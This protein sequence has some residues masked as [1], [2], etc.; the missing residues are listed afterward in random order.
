MNLTVQVSHV[1]WSAP[2]QGAIIVGTPLNAAGEPAGEALA[3]RMPSRTL[4]D[5]ITLQGDL[6]RLH[7]QMEEYRGQPQFHADVAI[8]VRPYGRNMVATL[9][10][11]RFPGVGKQ[12]AQ[13][14]WERF[15]AGLRDVLEEG[16]LERLTEVVTPESAKV[17]VQGWRDL[18]PGDV[19]DWLDEHRFPVGLGAS[20]LKF[21][22]ECAA[23]KLHAD[24][25]RLLAFGQPWSTVDKI[26]LERLAVAPE[27]PRREHAAVAEALYRAYDKDGSTALDRDA[28]LT[29]AR[30]ILGG[31]QQQAERAVG[32]PHQG[33]GWLL[34]AS[35][36]LYQT[37]GAW[38]MERYVA[39]RLSRMIAHQDFPAQ[40]DL[41]YVHPI[42]FGPREREKIGYALTAW[43]ANNHPLGPGQKQAVWTALKHQFAVISGGAGVGK[44]TIL[45]AFYAG[46][47]A[48]GSE[49]VQMALAGRAAKRMHDATKR[50]AMTIAGFLHG[51]EEDKAQSDQS[52]RMDTR[53]YV[54]DEAS[55]LD[56]ATLYQVLRKI[57]PG[58]RLVLV[59]DDMQLPP[60]G[61]GL[62]F[63]L[64]C[65]PES[66]APRSHL[67][68]VYRQDGSTGIPAIGQ[69]IRDGGW[70][71]IPPYAGPGVG[72]SILPCSM[73]DVAD[74]IARLYDELVV[75]EGDENEVQILATSKGER[76][77]RPGTV[78]H[79]NRD[80]YQQRLSDRLAVKVRT[81]LSGFCEGCPIMFIEN[82][83]DRSLNNGSLGMI[84]RA[85]PGPMFLVKG[86]DEDTLV[87]LAQAM[88]SDGSP[89]EDGEI[90][91]AEAVIDGK[92]HYLTETDLLE[93]IQRS[94]GITI[95]KAQGSQWNRVIVP[96]APSPLL[97]RT[98]VYTAVTRAVRQVVLVGDI[99]AAEKAVQEAPRALSRLTG[100]TSLL[101]GSDE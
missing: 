53:T 89:R 80:L 92:V 67:T 58:G 90:V 12:K 8:L 42:D 21:Y 63:H 60:I 22:G 84:T 31:D 26:A 56:I 96:I 57:G 20:L 49:V 30:T 73:G 59:G 38:L 78:L 94:F 97:D 24:P 16:D 81:G 17:L 68:Q 47:D 82:D 69:A 51:G 74:V 10:G 35:S 88:G 15:G 43:Q 40:S 99:A 83:W 46:L 14:L 66:P 25:Y 36:G 76:R 19:I 13:A 100:L 39:Q 71:I 34:D 79:I 85:F 6:W 3:V 72:V 32:T 65:R 55:M 7:G 91:W 41:L 11:K 98:L 50:K 101:S 52:D 18:N 2:G 87:P 27:D 61:A 54:V 86:K 29:S 1:R 4:A 62:T 33:G 5:Q 75:H 37:S 77:E 23:D 28:L 95:H 44:T 45:M 70:P 64:L 48:L 93:R 9:A